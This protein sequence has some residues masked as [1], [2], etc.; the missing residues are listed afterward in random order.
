[1]SALACIGC[2]KEIANPDDAW[3]EITGWEKRRKQG[4]TNAVFDRKRT[5]IAMCDT[6]HTRRRFGGSTGQGELFDS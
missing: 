2:R 1:L 5:G 4:G 6:C 3:W